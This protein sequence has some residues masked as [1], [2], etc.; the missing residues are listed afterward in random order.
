VIN[1]LIEGA[2]G[3]AFAL[4]VNLLVL[5]I[6]A[7][8]L[9]TA[10]VGVLPFALGAAAW[11]GRARKSFKRWGPVVGIILALLALLF[12]PAYGAAA[13]D[14]HVCLGPGAAEQLLQEA[15]ATVARS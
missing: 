4:E 15:A 10:A 11:E 13:D 8:G 14:D 9:L 5:G 1:W 6:A 12:L 2:R 3:L 7:V